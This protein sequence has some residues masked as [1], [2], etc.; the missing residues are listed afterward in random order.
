MNDFNSNSARK[1]EQK[2]KNNKTP[3]KSNK[4]KKP[5]KAAVVLFGFLSTC[6]LT[7]LV[8][9]SY[10]LINVVLYVNGDIV[11]NLD[12]YK[13]NQNQTSF[14]YAYDKSGNT[15]EIARLHGEEDRVWVDLDDMSPYIKDAVIALEDT[16]F[17]KHHGVDWIRTIG[18][19]VKPQN[20]GQ[21]GSTIT[22]QLIKNLTNNKE[23]TVVRKFYEIL[24]ALNLEENYDKD[25]ILEAYLNTL[26][27][28]SGC[29]GVK[30]ASEKYFGKDI[31]ELNAAE[32]AVLVS[33]TKAPTKYNPLINPDKNRERQVYCLDEMKE[34]GALTEEE[35]N[36]AINYKLIFTN[37]ED[38]VPKVDETQVKK[39]NEE[40][41][42]SFYVDYVRQ[43]VQNDLMEEYGY[44]KQQAKDKILYGGLKIYAAVDLDIQETL[45]DVYVNRKSFPDLKSKD[46]ELVQSAMT[47]MD[48]QGRV[49]A[50]VG[51]AGEKSGKLGLNRAANS[52]RQ[53]GSTIKPLATYAPAIEMNIYNYSSKVKDY[54][55]PING[56]L[57]PH[58]VDK[59]LGSGNNVTIE[60]AI[61]KSLNTVPARIINYDVGIDNSFEFIRDRFHLSKLD[62]KEDRTLSPLA[63]GALT[64]GTTTVE[65]AAAYATF[66]NGGLYYKPYS[67]YKVTNSQGTQILLNNEQPK[68]ER[69]IS[70][71][72]SD[73][74]CELLQTVDT[75][76]YGTAS[77]VRKFQ[78]M[79]KTGTTSSDKDRWFCAG[80]PYYVAAVWVGF[81]KPESLGVSVNP[82]GKIFMTVF[83]K[84]HKGLEEKE[85]PKSSGTVQKRYCRVTGKLAGSSCY[86]TGMG[87]YK[88]TSMPSVCTS[89]QASSK[90]ENSI[91]EAVSNVVDGISDNLSNILDEIIGVR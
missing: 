60:Y 79:A 9:V 5:S 86:S 91:G 84:I 22:Q 3:K 13:A 26:Y 51:E 23:V 36:Q 90:N 2:S 62:E 45:E 80:T 75:S 15:V 82:G 19:I 16:R 46:G 21:G 29:Y 14:I 32:C 69:A 20:L 58:N 89:C 34:N 71:E 54:A 7:V 77:N 81:D 43:C 85:F 78:I 31:S 8:V 27:L 10:V 73:I 25:T 11:V 59:T 74:M 68:S 67:Y 61:Q 17:E 55:I 30:T 33:I 28:G 57:W 48:Y 35:Y 37:S 70:E 50:I 64:N 38:Y 88:I 41:I 4:K 6:V 63:T 39:E 76:Y 65:M 44:S 24:S 52:Y 18:V 87:W 66:G 72:T 56:K 12:E 83:D 49:V 40:Q 42:N 1:P 47:I 53:P